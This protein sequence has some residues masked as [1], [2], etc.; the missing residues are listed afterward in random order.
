MKLPLLTIAIPTYN[1]APKAEAQLGR[2]ADDLSTEIG[3]GEVELM[4]VD[5]ASADDTPARLASMRQRV[6]ALRAE[7][8]ERNLGLI[9]NYRRCLEL[10]RGRYVW[11]CGDDDDLRSDAPSRVLH[12][13]RQA[14]EKGCVLVIH[15]F[16]MRNGITGQRAPASFYAKLGNSVH[17]GGNIVPPRELLACGCGGMLW[18]TGNILRTQEARAFAAEERILADNL[19]LTYYVGV[20]AVVSAPV[21]YSGETLFEMLTHTTS[22][23]S[24]GNCKLLACDFPV[25]R[26]LLGRRLIGQELAKVTDE[27]FS[28]YGVAKGV[29]GRF[30]LRHLFLNRS[31][32]W[33]DF[34]RA[35]SAGAYNYGQLTLALIGAVFGYLFRR[36]RAGKQAA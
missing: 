21:W 35:V 32:A 24:R 33:R 13:V 31:Q 29:N 14:D 4:C 18:I 6:P 20:R 30:A 25:V 36:L 27:A 34:H 9:G 10:A 26:E 28:D 7:R 17:R 2:I 23:A 1:R 19:A 12:H 8:N 15:D 5:N 3:S 16:T 22:W 11:V